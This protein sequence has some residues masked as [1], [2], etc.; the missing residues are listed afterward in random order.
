MLN[1][2][3]KVVLS[4]INRYIILIFII[5]VFGVLIVISQEKRE[6]GTLF[7][8]NEEQKEQLEGRKVTL[9]EKEKEWLE[10]H[11]G[12]IRLAPDP[13]FAPFEFFDKDSSYVGMGADYLRLLE[14]KTGINFQIVHYRDWGEIVDAAQNMTVDV[15]G[16]ANDTEERK[17]YM[18]FTQPYLSMKAVIVTRTGITRELDLDDLNGMKVTVVRGYV[19]E[20]WLKKDY[21]HIQLDP[22]PN[23]VTGLRK[24]A[25]GLCDAMV[26][27]LSI[28][29]Y[30]IDEEGYSNLMVAGETGEKVDL[31]IGVRNDWP[32]LVS[33]LNKGID[34][35]TRKE[36]VEIKNKWLFHKRIPFYETTQFWWLLLLILAGVVFILITV[37]T[38]NSRLRKVVIEKTA[39]L[40]KEKEQL[41]LAN[42]RL[43]DALDKAAESDRLTKSFLANISHE[44]R[45]PM[46]SIMGFA[47]LIE[48]DEANPEERQHYA[49]LMVKGGQQLLTILDNI[50][51]LSKMDSGLIKPVVKHIDV[52]QLL[53]E[54]CELLEPVAVKAGLE[55]KFSHCGSEVLSDLETDPVLL[56]QVL[57]NI[58]TN[59]IKYTARGSVA[60]DV[61]VVGKDIKISVADTGI[62]IPVQFREGIFEP[63]Q[64]IRHESKL[65]GAGLGLAIARKIMNVLNGKIWIESNK[66]TGSVFY[67]LIPIH[68]DEI[69]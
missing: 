21:P 16:A 13:D 8:V 46:N 26:A 61:C 44:I 10:Q 55:M 20:E 17:K 41:R 7:N 51:D 35:V 39:A 67:I 23:A 49:T 22:V 50:I 63:F 60:V 68:G 29:S 57:N 2:L 15:F 56:Q 45:T 58:L 18:N 24:V 9:S 62:G 28:A 6:I 37:L 66:P 65:E 1:H 25:F 43:V 4:S 19:W 33:I 12:K 31:A 36:V 64:Q 48:I 3:N 34:L 53:S 54:T 59:A 30:Y 38:F 32:E 14:R 40:S 11:N 5:T 47:Q 42:Q 27:S 52:I 69:V